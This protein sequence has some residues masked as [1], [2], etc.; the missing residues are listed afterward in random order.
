MLRQWK[1]EMEK[2]GYDW[3]NPPTDP[4]ACHCAKG[5]GA[6]RK[7]RSGDCGNPRCG[8]CHSEKQTWMNKRR[9]RERRDAIRRE[10]DTM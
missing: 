10:L 9:R 2:H 3:R 4:E 8:L 5:I 7:R 1:L 6:M